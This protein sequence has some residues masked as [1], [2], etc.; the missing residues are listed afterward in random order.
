VT[1]TDVL[2]DA[3]EYSG[4]SVY[5]TADSKT[6]T[7]KTS[8]FK[9]VCK[10]QTVTVTGEKNPELN[11]VTLRFDIKCRIREGYDLSGYIKDGFY[12]IPNAAKVKVTYGYGDP[13]ETEKDTN[14]AVIKLEAPPP[15]TFLE[16][17]KEID[18]A[19]IVAAHGNPVFIFKAEG[20]DIKGKERTY[21]EAVEFTEQSAAADGKKRETAVI[22]VKAGVYTVTEER[23]MR[24]SFGGI[25]SV[26]QGTA[27]GER[28]IFDVSDAKGGSAVFYN[29]KTT[30]E[31]QGHTA[32]VRNHFGKE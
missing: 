23:T 14:K 27:S 9:A 13:A 32:L 6:F 12:A 20:T 22:K 25:Y 21:Y 17:T 8:L 15:D 28:V 26:T 30:D 18:A 16:I 29:K 19:D 10:G 5:T 11:N 7:D 2:E 4:F 31:E 3:L 24:Y 1:V